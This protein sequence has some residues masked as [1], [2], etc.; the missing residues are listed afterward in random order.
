MM[1]QTIAHTRTY[2][3]LILVFLLC[4]GEIS[5]L[6]IVILIFTKNIHI[7]LQIYLQILRPKILVVLERLMGKKKFKNDFDYDLFNFSMKQNI[8]FYKCLFIDRDFTFIIN[9]NF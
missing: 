4:E 6:S 5:R 9:I 8:V 7:Y 3:L 1:S 2:I